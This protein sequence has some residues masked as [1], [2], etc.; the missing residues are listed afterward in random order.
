[1]SP[2]DSGMARQVESDGTAGIAEVTLRN[3]LSYVR[4]AGPAVFPF[5]PP[6]R[7]NSRSYS[8]QQG[9]PVLEQLCEPLVFRCRTG[10][11]STSKWTLCHCFAST[12]EKSALSSKSCRCKI[13]CAAGLR[14]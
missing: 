11:L 10:Q 8:A 4:V 12:R 6:R 5:M 9:T 1:M 7:T 3:W 13:T 14:W 2:A